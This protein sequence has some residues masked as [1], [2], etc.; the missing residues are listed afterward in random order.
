MLANWLADPKNPLTPRVMVNR[1]WQYHFGAGIVATASDFGVMGERP[2][3][4]QLL[5]Y[6]ASTFVENGWSIKKMHRQIML[7]NLYQES[8][9]FQAQAAAVDPENKLLWRYDRHRLEGEAIRDSMLF[10]SGLLNSKMGGPG[11]NPPLPP[12]RRRRRRRAAGVAGA[13]GGLAEERDARIDAAEANRRSV[14]IFS[15]A[16]CGLPNA[17]GLRRAESAGELQ[18]AIPLGDPV[19][20][21]D[22]D[23]RPAGAGMVAR[24]GRPSAE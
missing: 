11:I 7:S 21:V 18:P 9:A 15:E 2:S 19:A 8:S 14:Y 13:T 12:A 4:P 20:V 6:L 3:N 22:P 5:D 16:Q 17:G 1:I 23:E 24:A 10:V